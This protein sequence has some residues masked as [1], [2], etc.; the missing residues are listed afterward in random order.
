MTVM[1][2]AA[3][4]RRGPGGR[5]PGPRPEELFI[6]CLFAAG[7]GDCG[8]MAASVPAGCSGHITR[9]GKRGSLVGGIRRKVARR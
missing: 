3:R 9:G 4:A 1:T 2:A 6:S 5:G 8:S 7:Q